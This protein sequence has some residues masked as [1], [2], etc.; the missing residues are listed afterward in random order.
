V[1]RWLVSLTPAQL[2]KKVGQI[3]ETAE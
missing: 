2:D 1:H 3:K